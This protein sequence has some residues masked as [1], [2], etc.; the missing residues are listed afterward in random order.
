VRGQLLLDLRE[1]FV[2]QFG[3]ARV[4]RR[5]RTD[6]ARLA[7]REHEFGIADDKHRRGDDG[8]AQ[9]LQDGGQGHGVSPSARAIE[10]RLKT[11]VRL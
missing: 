6:D 3:G 8:Q 1:P 9:I 5:E 4:E 10:I 2:E 7:L 11:V